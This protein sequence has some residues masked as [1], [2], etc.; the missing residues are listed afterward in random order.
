MDEKKAWMKVERDFRKWQRWSKIK[1]IETKAIARF[2]EE[3]KKRN[4][5]PPAVARRFNDFLSKGTDYASKMLKTNAK[6]RTAY[7]ERRATAGNSK[8][9]FTGFYVGNIGWFSARSTSKSY[10]SVTHAIKAHIKY[11]TNEKREDLRLHEGLEIEFWQRLA[12]E[13]TQKRWDARIAGK[14]I[15]TLPNDLSDDEAFE[16]V[17]KFIDEQLNPL[18]IGIAIHRNAGT[19]SGKEN[20][21]AHIL[22]S[23]RK[24]DGKKMRLGREDLRKLHIEWAKTIENLGYTIYKSPLTHQKLNIHHGGKPDEKTIKFI[25]LKRRIWAIIEQEIDE[26]LKEEEKEKEE[27][28]KRQQQQQQQQHPDLLIKFLKKAK[29]RLQHS[30]AEEEAKKEGKHEKEKTQQQRKLRSKFYAPKQN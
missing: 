23:A 22:F 24:K 16:I 10:K 19:I 17:K 4:M 30:H 12:E 7:Y 9:T 29:E 25:Q 20:L 6:L 18:H 13:E 3:G 8:K 21:H 28:E 1:E 14:L 11:L 5:I 26:T 15:L 2:F 27:Q